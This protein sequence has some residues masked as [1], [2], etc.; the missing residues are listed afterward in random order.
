MFPRNDE[1]MS[2]LK[3]EFQHTDDGSF[4]WESLISAYFGLPYL[5]GFWPM[6]SG[7]SGGNPTVHDLSGNELHLSNT[8]V[9]LGWIN[10]HPGLPVANFGIGS[11]DRLQ[12]KDEAAFH[13]SGLSTGIIS[14]TRG[15]TAGAW[16]RPVNL[17]A[18]FETIMGQWDSG[19]N[20]RE[21][22]IRLNTGGTADAFIS[23][24]GTNEAF[25]QRSIGLLDDAWNFLCLQWSPSGQSDFLRIW[26]NNGY[27]ENAGIQF[28][29]LND[30]KKDFGMGFRFVSSPTRTDY[31]EGQI[32]MA[33]LC[34]CN[35]SDAAIR[36]LYY[37]TRSV[38]QSR[39][40]WQ[41]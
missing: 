1:V 7:G 21:W 35:I 26:V 39:S 23:S 31:F 13:T 15:L 34:G 25:A 38:F 24:N 10:S 33:F 6:S 30:S 14:Y 40:Q 16:V 36:R 27:T 32:S 19:A 11:S 5:K 8:G 22:M 12:R 9:Q 41:S 4:A 3:S 17:A 20:D 2:S 28:A 29:D 18:A 37:R